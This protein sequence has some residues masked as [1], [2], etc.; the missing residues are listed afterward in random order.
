MSNNIIE[1]MN[2]VSRTLYNK[3]GYNSEEY[4]AYKRVY[5]KLADCIKKESELK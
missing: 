3:Y 2:F 5:D 1:E 4:K